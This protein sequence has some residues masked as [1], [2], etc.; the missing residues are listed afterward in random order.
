MVTYHLGTR[1]RRAD[2][3]PHK[4][5]Y[6]EPGEEHFDT[7]LK[8]SN[9][10][11]RMMDGLTSSIHFLLPMTSLQPRSTRPLTMWLVPTTEWPPLSHLKDCIYVLEGQPRLQI[12]NLCHDLP[13]AGHFGQFKTCNQG[14]WSFWWLGLQAYIKNY[15]RSCN[16]IKKP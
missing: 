16:Y 4:D 13:L 1:N 8:A 10:I 2:A 5:K 15:I 9:F 12:L 11:N 3:L 14:L 7:M 6:L